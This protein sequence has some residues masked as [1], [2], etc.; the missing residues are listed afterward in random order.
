MGRGT[1]GE[2]Q[3]DSGNPWG[4][5]GRVEGPSRWFGTGRGTLV[6]VR[7]GHWPLPEV[8]HGSGIVPEVW[9]GSRDPP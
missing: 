1:L 7:E 2:V 9:D 4:G 6:K 5:A 8:Q 3:H